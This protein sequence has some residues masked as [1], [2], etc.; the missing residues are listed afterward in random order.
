[1]HAAQMGSELSQRE[2]ALRRLPLAYSLALRVRDTGINADMI[3]QF[4][5]INIQPADLDRLCRAAEVKL[6][7]AQS[8]ADNRYSVVPPK[9]DEIAVARY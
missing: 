4:V 3:R 5:N 2:Q 7:E 6:L 8:T 1:M 9:P